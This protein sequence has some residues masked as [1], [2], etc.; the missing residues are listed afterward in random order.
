MDLRFKAA[1]F[2]LRLEDLPIFG[3]SYIYLYI[4]TEIWSFLWKLEMGLFIGFCFYSMLSSGENVHDW[5]Q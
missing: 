1:Y 5:W 3:D 2:K 4:H